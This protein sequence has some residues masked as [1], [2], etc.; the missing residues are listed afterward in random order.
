MSEEQKKESAEYLENLK[1][2]MAGFRSGQEK[3]RYEHC[4]LFS[5]SSMT[6][7]TRKKELV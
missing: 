2:Q 7:A 3:K 5:R 4:L 1:K 6:V